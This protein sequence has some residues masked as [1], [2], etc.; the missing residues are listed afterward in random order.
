MPLL[1]AWQLMTG[2][3]IQEMRTLIIVV[4]VVVVLAVLAYLFLS[5]RGRRL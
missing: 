5:R 4:I 2:E 3:V 1:L